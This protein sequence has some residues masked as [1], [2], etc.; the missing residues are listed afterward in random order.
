MKKLDVGI[1]GLGSAGIVAIH[2]VSMKTQNYLA[3]EGDQE[4]TTCARVGCMPSKALILIAG[5]MGSSGRG[6]IME[7]VR[8]KRDALVA[9]VLKRYDPEKVVREWAHFIAPMTLEAGEEIYR[10][11]SIVI[12]TGSKPIVPPGWKLVPKKI[13]TT[14]TFFELESIPDSALVI[15]LGQVGI[16]LGQALARIGVKV[17]GVEM[18]ERIAGVQDPTIEAE[19]VK[20]LS[21][22]MEL[23]TRTMAKLNSVDGEVNVTL[24][25]GEWEEKR[26]YGLVILAT[27]RRPI[28]SPP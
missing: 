16:E 10:C 8:E 19:L 5:K 27:G 20:F 12:A 13:V 23:M 17:T 3:F 25:R 15:G 26:S 11:S 14:D 21:R 2:R 1:I 6:E 9:N 28:L 18:A 22:D 24:R 7:R 4:G